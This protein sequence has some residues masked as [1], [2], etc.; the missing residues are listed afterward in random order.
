[1]TPVE[2]RGVAIGGDNPLAIIAGPCVIENEEITLR[3]AEKLKEICGAVGLPLIFKSSYDK[4]NRSSFSSYRGPGLKKG[5]RTLEAVRRT[6]D[7][8][9]VSDVHSVEDVKPASEVLDMLQIPAFLCR[10]TDLILAVSGTG[11]PANIKKGQFLAPW[12]V[13]NIIDKFIST[14]NR[15]LLISERGSS[16]GYNNLVV[17]FRGLPIMR[18]FGYPVI[19]DVTHSLQLPGGKGSSSGGQREFAGPLARAAAAV[20]ID[21]LFMEVHPEPEK[22][23]CDGPNMIPLSG[24]GNMLASLKELHKMVGH[25]AVSSGVAKE[26]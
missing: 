10:Q 7:I 18:S 17:D 25:S 4:A 5:L 11:K 2:I 9:V 14:G 3:T 6:L 21:G 1:M 22:A 23:L 20:G 13:K 16:F 15:K 19:F 26:R 8:P 12:D 24:L